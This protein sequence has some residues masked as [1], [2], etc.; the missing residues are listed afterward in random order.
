MFT[1]DLEAAAT[2]DGANH[3]KAEHAPEARISTISRISSPSPAI[4]EEYVQQAEAINGTAESER[5]SDAHRANALEVAWSAPDDAASR[6][7]PS[8]SQRRYIDSSATALGKAIPRTVKTS[9][10]GQACDRCINFDLTLMPDYAGTNGGRAWFQWNCTKGHSIVRLGFR[11][12]DVLVAS[13]DC[14]AYADKHGVLY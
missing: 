9:Q 1:F 8:G 2:I 5:W 4:P 3:P 7:A 10:M 14:T 6:L 13:K 11:G 12:A